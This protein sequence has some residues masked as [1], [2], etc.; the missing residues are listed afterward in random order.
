MQQLNLFVSPA[1]PPKPLPA[2]AQN[3]MRNL[4][5][6]LLVAV[7]TARPSKQGL[8]EEEQ[9]GQSDD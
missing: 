9:E 8:R 7:M 5:S 1:T 6:N 4:L 3:N 2:E